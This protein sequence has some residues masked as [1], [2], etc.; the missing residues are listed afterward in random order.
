MITPAGVVKVLDF[1]LARSSPDRQAE[2]VLSTV[3]ANLTEPGLGLG[4]VAYMSPEQARGLP[5]ERRTDLWAFGC[6]LYEMLAGRPAFSGQTTTDVIVKIVERDPD[7]SA[8]PPDLAPTIGS[9][10]PAMLS[11]GSAAT[12]ARYR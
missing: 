3:A 10:A 8:L 4:T 11:E 12:A 5:V 2:D 9:A 1:G 6:V 7:W